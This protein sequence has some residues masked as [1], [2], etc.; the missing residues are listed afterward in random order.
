MTSLF[1]RKEIFVDKRTI[2]VYF[3]ELSEI[4]GN[5]MNAK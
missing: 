2:R 4:F 3:I 1:V 5:D